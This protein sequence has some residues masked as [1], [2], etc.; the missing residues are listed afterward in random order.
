V[1]H[2]QSAFVTSIIHESTQVEHAANTITLTLAANVELVPG[3]RFTLG[4][5]FLVTRAADASNKGGR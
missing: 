3:V 1:L 2:V 5:C 4:C